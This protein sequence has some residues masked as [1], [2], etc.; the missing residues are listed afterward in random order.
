[1][2]SSSLKNDIINSANVQQINKHNGSTNTNLASQYVSSATDINSENYDPMLDIFELFNDPSSLNDINHLLK[3]SKSY[4][5]QLG[6]EI[7][8]QRQEYKKILIDSGPNHDPNEL[9]N[10]VLQL[11]DSFQNLKGLV[12]DTG[13]TINSM[14][15]NIKKLDQSKKN[16]TFTMTTLKRLQMLVTAYDRLEKQLE[17]EK[18]IK[19]YLEIK[20]LLSAVLELNAYFQD[21]KSIDDVNK[22]HKLISSMKNKIVNDIFHDFELEYNEELINDELIEACH[23]LESLGEAYVNQLETWYINTALKDITEIFRSTE[24]AGSL[25][26]LNRRFIYFQ[27]ILSN[28]ESKHLKNF[29]KSWNMV[30]KLTESFC[31]YT[32]N[33]LKEV[34]GKESR[35]KTSTDVNI[36]LNSLSHTLD[37]EQFLNKKFKYYKDFDD[38]LKNSEQPNFTKSISDVFE[39]YLNIWIDNQA[40]IIEKKLVEFLT[41]SY[42]FKKTGD[43]IN[44]NNGDDGN[45]KKQDESI[46]VLESA[47]EI[48]RLYRQILSQLSKLT[49]GKSLIRLSKIF[50]KYLTQYQ[51]KILDSILP[52]SNSLVSV[53]LE[54]QLE[55]VDMICLVLNT[56]SYC[57]STIF[58]LE[59][60]IKSLIEP[61]ALGSQIEFESSNNGFLQLIAYCINLLF[62][63]IEN[64]IQFSWRE[65]INFNWRVLNEVIG[66]SRY[67]TSLKSIIKENCEYMFKRI[68]KVIYIR[69]LIDKLI[70]MLLNNILLNIIK[71]EPISVM[72]AEQFKLDLQEL[73]SF[74]NLLPTLTEGGDKILSSNSFKTNVNTKFKNIDNLMKILMVPNKP[75]D[76][77]INSYFS[78]IGDSNF[79]NFMKILQ[80]KGVLKTEAT[81][82][83]KFKYMDMF[84]LQMGS[85][86][87]NLADNNDQLKESDEYLEKL[88]VVNSTSTIR[89]THG[90]TKSGSRSIYLPNTISSNTSVNNSTNVLTP[91]EPPVPELPNTPSLD[92]GSTSPKPNFGFF[93][94]PKIDTNSIE[95][96]FVKTFSENKTSLNEKFNKFFKRGE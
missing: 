58:Q 94:S 19:K 46:N 82:K 31:T 6:I 41:P 80:L 45:S 73:K 51:H 7:Q 15:A 2:V 18:Q 59:D 92:Q 14:T 64:D 81:E 33:D 8:Q 79:S 24:E 29:P 32:K 44:G 43:G 55:G 3:Y 63:K 11:L 83:D 71:L 62:Y 5:S 16:L 50:N 22:L 91:P 93:S 34:L 86:E 90:H 47:A 84:K 17:N 56:A 88:N 53:G 77:F 54:S 65:L 39:P 4:Q 57:S 36:L 72:M 67:M 68:S 76:V 13:S 78:I 27:N 26:N 60:K 96:N 10:E 48:F 25:D 69:N 21:F 52:D 40:L 28:F 49:T 38:Q 9:D 20:Q 30:L 89:K 35:L 74:I 85:F 37:F 75:M 70:D 12:E 66:E 95:K 23:I 61:T 42:M 87:E 1:M